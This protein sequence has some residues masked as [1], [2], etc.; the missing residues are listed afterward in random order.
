MR[1]YFLFLMAL[2]VHSNA[3]ASKGYCEK[4]ESYA[5]AIYTALIEHDMCS[6]QN[7]CNKKQL[8]FGN[9]TD[10]IEHSLYGLCDE[11]L[12]GEIISAVA[13]EYAQ[14]SS[15]QKVSVNFYCEQK[16]N[17]VNNF[18]SLFSTPRIT[19]QISGSNAPNQQPKPTP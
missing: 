12:A 17:L 11:A 2:L 6:D 3:D 15:N 1:P 19:F 16:E 4:G 5:G 8:L 9:C 14:R 18:R 7:V 13:N 10:E